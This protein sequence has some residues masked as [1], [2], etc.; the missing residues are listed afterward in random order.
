V[1]ATGY[2]VSMFLA[3]WPFAGHDVFALVVDVDAFYEIAVRSFLVN[4]PA[5]VGC[6]WQHLAHKTRK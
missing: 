1:D 3:V 2:L 5:G 4:V 6:G